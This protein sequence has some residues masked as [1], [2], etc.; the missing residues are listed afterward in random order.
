MAP[1]IMKCE[2]LGE[3]FVTVD[4]FGFTVDKE[5]LLKNLDQGIKNS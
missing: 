2:D 4:K 1:K 5:T 3:I